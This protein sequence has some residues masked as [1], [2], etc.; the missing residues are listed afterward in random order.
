MQKFDLTDRFRLELRWTKVAYTKEG[1]CKIT[2]A[3]FTGPALADALKLENN[4]H[5]LLDF[6]KQY[7]VLVENVY[8]GKFSWG[9]VTYEKDGTISLKNTKLTH[10]TELN[11]V[12]K[13]KDSDYLII[14][15]SNH[16]VETHPFNPVY[17]TYVVNEDTALYKFGG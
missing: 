16:E 13:L 14:D 10:D 15:T 11:K 4:D 1:V 17:R 2:G 8:I 12:P 7:L 6:F 9:E 3:K 5:I